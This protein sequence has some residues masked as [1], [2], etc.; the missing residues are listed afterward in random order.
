M[1]F[2][3]CLIAAVIVT[4]AL[5]AHGATV[6]GI[7]KEGD[8]TGSAI[9]QAIVTLGSFGGAT[10]PLSDTTDATGAFK[11]TNVLSGAYQLGAAKTGYQTQ[12]TAVQISD[13]TAT[14][15]QNLFLISKNSR[16]TIS[17]IIT[18]FSTA[19]AISGALVVISRTGMETPLDTAVT[20]ANGKYSFDSLAPGT[21][22]IRVSATGYIAGSINVTITTASQ[23]VTIKLV[24]VTYGKITGRVTADSL[25]GPVLGGANLVLSIRSMGAYSIVDSAISNADGEYIFNKV[26]SGQSYAIAASLSGYVS[27][28]ANHANQTMGIDT[29][30]IPL[31]KIGVGT[32]LV[33]VLKRSD[34]SAI[35][36]AAVVAA[37]LATGAGSGLIFSG[38]TASSGDVVF[39]NFEVPTPTMG[40]RVTVSCAN[41]VSAALAAWVPKNGK[42]TIIMY[43]TAST[44]G[45][46]TLA[47][48][49]KDST[50]KSPLAYVRIMVNVV[51][52]GTGA[53]SL[54][55]ID[56]TGSDGRYAVT[57]MPSTSNQATVTATLI[58]YRTFTEYNFNLGAPN[59]ADT[60]ILTLAL[61]KATAINP[62]SERKPAQG[63]PEVFITSSGVIRLSAI[64][65]SGT[66]FVVTV[67]GRLLLRQSIGA[68]ELRVVLPAVYVK[69][70]A[71]YVVTITQG[72][73][74]YRKRL[75]LQ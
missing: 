20:G 1:G 19:A 8:S 54:T 25:R 71:A 41:Y 63:N 68:H 72:S 65:Q 22:S 64:T 69:S 74:V 59:R 11:F 62:V 7:V 44:G 45:A 52:T 75:L 47:G 6:K 29:V 24:A 49:I 34:S 2:K 26:Q 21:Y 27:A 3:W 13:S 5:S 37:Q 31:A 51:G 9:A 60:T 32:L 35:A 18:N 46:K 4:A 38:Q 66:I 55:F 56:S 10:K 12:Q 33:T 53:Q 43:L 28:M 17:G 14:Y 58:G 40:F 48:I 30:D 39:E 57:G 36:Q 70:G 23:G 61:L 42:D 15:S 73:A 16:A 50:S 67:G